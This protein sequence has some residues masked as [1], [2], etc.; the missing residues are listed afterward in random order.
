VRRLLILLPLLAGCSEPKVS[1]YEAPKDGWGVEWTAPEGWPSKPGDGMRR[2]TYV[3][4][5]AE[6]TVI[7]LPGEAGGP[8]ANV[9]RWRGQ[10][11]LGPAKTVGGRSLETPLGTA[12]L[13]E[14]ENKGKKTA[15][16]FLMVGGESWFFKL[17]GPSSDVRKGKAGL[18]S[19]L[20]SLRRG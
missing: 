10:L 7:S 9:N 1:F 11:G 6:L 19:L 12:T 16:A 4:G 17:T 14:F 18:L 20:G 13:V 3:A 15:A 8:L 2:A 5:A